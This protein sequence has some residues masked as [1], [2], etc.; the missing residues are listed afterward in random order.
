[1]KLTLESKSP[2]RLLYSPTHKVDIAREGDNKA[3]IDYKVDAAPAGEMV[4]LYSLEEGDLASS[5]LSFREPGEAGT[6][7][8]S[9]AP[10]RDHERAGGRPVLILSHD[11][12]NKRSGTV[13]AIA[14]TSQPHKAGFPLTYP[15]DTKQL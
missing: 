4:V 11:I 3:K 10:N 5:L 9:L 8:L 1:M 7:M 6:F 12:F 2:I 15:L 14:I 13:I